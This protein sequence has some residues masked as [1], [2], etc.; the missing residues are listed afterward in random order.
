MVRNL[1]QHGLEEGISTRLLVYAAKLM[2]HG[3][4]P[5]DACDHAVIQSMTDDTEMQEAIVEIVSGI[6]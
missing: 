4:S 2:R 5:R 1:R 3:I 6:F